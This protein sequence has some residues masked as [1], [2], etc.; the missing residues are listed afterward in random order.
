MADIRDL[1]LFSSAESCHVDNRT[2]PIRIT[3]KIFRVRTPAAEVDVPCTYRMTT[4]TSTVV[5]LRLAG[6]V[7][8]VKSKCLLDSFQREDYLSLCRYCL[9]AWWPATGGAPRIPQKA[10]AVA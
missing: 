10:H 4:K 2:F 5:H 7:V 6:L 1:Q 9:H 3:L 8:V